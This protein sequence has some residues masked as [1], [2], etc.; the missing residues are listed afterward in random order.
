MLVVHG[1]LACI[2]QMTDTM[3]DPIGLSNFHVIHL[4]REEHVQRGVPRVFVDVL[5]YPER[6]CAD[7]SI[8]D[9]VGATL[10]DSR[11]V[12]CKVVVAQVLAPR[13]RRDQYGRPLARLCLSP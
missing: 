9:D 13:L 2:V 6:Q 7:V 8:L 1:S 11:E 3:P 5:G 4:Y 10:F 12:I